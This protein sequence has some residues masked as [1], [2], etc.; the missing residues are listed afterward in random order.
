MI[1]V[2]NM[3]LVIG[4][5]GRNPEGRVLDIDDEGY[6]HVLVGLITTYRHIATLVKLRVQN[7]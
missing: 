1:N 5:L 7:G 2:G 3:V 4:Y 6:A